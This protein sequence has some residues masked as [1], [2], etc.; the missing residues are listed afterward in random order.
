MKTYSIKIYGASDDLVYVDNEE[1]GSFDKPFYALFSDGT[2]I[3]IQYG[4]N[5][6]TWLIQTIIHGTAKLNYYR[7]QEND[8]DL[9]VFH[10]DPDA[11]TYSDV[12]ILISNEPIK[13]VKYGHKKLSSLIANS[14]LTDKIIAL[15]ENTAGGGFFLHELE[16]DDFNSFKEKLDE[17]ATGKTKEVLIFAITGTLT[18]PRNDIVEAIEKAGNRFSTVLNSKT[19]YLV[20]GVDPGESKLEKARELGTKMIKEGDFIKI[21][22]E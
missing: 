1:Y 12:I 5:D 18:R 19:D 11:P 10:N 3:K 6:A 13:L 7:G 16:A 22:N 4:A 21:I 9:S 8:A 14:S 2:Q 15:I 20:V 17:I